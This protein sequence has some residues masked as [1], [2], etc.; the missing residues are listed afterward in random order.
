MTRLSQTVKN[1][2]DAARKNVKD[3]MKATIKT[4]DHR[5]VFVLSQLHPLFVLA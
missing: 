2:T 5:F 3:F 4:P 1:A